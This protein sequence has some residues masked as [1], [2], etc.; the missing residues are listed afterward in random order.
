MAV[1][2]FEDLKKN[3]SLPDFLHDNYGWEYAPGSTRLN[4][5][6][7]SP[8]GDLI[9]IKRNAQGYYTYFNVH[10]DRVKGKTIL[11][12]MQNVMTKGGKVPTLREVG[13]ILQ[14]YIDEGKTVLPDKSV[15][16]LQ[17]EMLNPE[18]VLDIVRNLKSIRDTKNFV[19]LKERGIDIENL[20]RTVNWKNVF[21]ENRV[22][23]DETGKVY[24]NICVKLVNRE[25]VQGF[26]QRNSMF[27]GIQGGKFDSVANSGYD[28]KRPLDTLYIGESMIDCISYDQMYHY[29]KDETN[30]CYISSEGSFTEGQLTTLNEVIRI[31]KPQ[32]I[33]SL[34]DNDRAGQ[35]YALKLL[36]G[37]ATKNDSFSYNVSVVKD[38]NLVYV[39]LQTNEANQDELVSKLFPAQK[40]NEYTEDK[41]QIN[42]TDDKSYE[43][44]FPYVKEVISNYVKNIGEYKLGKHFELKLSRNSDFNDDLRENLGI[45]K[46]ENQINNNLTL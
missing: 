14:K 27:K 36:G 29:K 10:D 30:N 17:N 6:M 24:N 12:F 5:K 11:D 9:V 40:A 1:I 2:K 15:Y 21:F 46:K 39:H 42:K 4:P 44:S 20:I 25:G 22:V 19:F 37:L 3:I 43:V 23:D 8:E 16:S 45:Q 32:K 34:F 13:E 18:K 31:N 7:R 26:S 33:V 35:I 38:E 41:F 28:H